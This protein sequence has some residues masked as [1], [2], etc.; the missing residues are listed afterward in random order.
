MAVSTSMTV[1]AMTPLRMPGKVD[2][3]RRSLGVAS[4]DVFIA[5]VTNSDEQGG[6][7]IDS[8]G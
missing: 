4:K 6:M 5:L 2:A 8:L 3:P 7:K 1:E